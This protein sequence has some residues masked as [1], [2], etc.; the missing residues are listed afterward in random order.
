MEPMLDATMWV[1]ILSVGFIAGFIDAVAGGGGMLTVPTLLASGLPPHV[2]LGTNKLASTFGSSIASYTFYRKKLFSPSFWRYALIYTAIGSILGTVIVSYIDTELLEKGLPIL[3][4]ATAIYTLLAKNVATDNVDLPSNMA[5]LKT[6]QAI[7]GI[8]L[9][10]YD[11]VAGP[12]TGAFW[13]TSSSI[14]YKVN[15]LLSSGLAR[16]CNFVS[17]ICSLVTFIYL[18]HVNILLGLSMGIFLML[19]AWVG[20]HSAIKFGSKFI[21]P[22]FTLVVVILSL[23]LAYNAWF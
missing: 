8:V 16:S 17:N 3:I 10:L 9:G 23:N 15:L 22:V 21:R 11:G 1:T 14:L 18:G 2:T 4:M 20:A 19:G 12:G 6:K 7:Q 13:V 5:W